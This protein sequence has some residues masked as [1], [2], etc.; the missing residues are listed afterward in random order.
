MTTLLSTSETDLKELLE[1]LRPADIEE[2]MDSATFYKGEQYYEWGL[3]AEAQYN[4][5]KTQLLARV[6]GSQDYTVQIALQQGSVQASCDCPVTGVCKHIAAVMLYAANESDAIEVGESREKG[7]L[8][9]QH[10]MAL[11]KEELVMRLLDYAP[12]EFLMEIHNRHAGEQE[13]QDAFTRAEGAIRKLFSNTELLYSPDD[14]ATHLH[15]H[16]R[17]LSGLEHQL[18]EELSPLIFYT[19]RK[20]E[21][22]FDNGYLYDDDYETTFELPDS[23]ITLVEQYIQALPYEAK[24]T[25]LKKLDDLLSETAYDVFESLAGLSQDSFNE[26]E[27]PA[28]KDMLLQEYQDLSIPLTEEYYVL[29]RSLLTDAEKEELLRYLREIDSSWVLELAY[30]YREED[31]VPEALEMLATGLQE[32]PEVYAD[33]Q[34]YALYLQLLDGQGMDPGPAAHQAL[35]AFASSSML[36]KIAVLEGIEELKPYEEQLEES[37]PQ[38]Y[39]EYLEKTGRLAEALQLLKNNDTIWSH[40]RHVFFKKH[41]EDFPQDAIH[42]LQQVIDSN[43]QYTG[44]P[45]YYKIIEALKLIRQVEPARAASIAADIRANYSNR[46]NLMRLLNDL[47][48]GSGA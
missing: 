21:E 13:A 47:E 42:H 41:I 15:R 9:H 45:H 39:L 32:N 36:L 4:F 25:F 14:F 5:D 31:R 3:V 48:G 23:F 6:E 28:V 7:S 24:T 18:E 16:I 20:I 29:V 1:S 43:L 2:E 37:N 44:N 10:L 12:D 8:V 34:V 19:I 30:L 26:D 11:P 40:Y 46:P 17:R 22:A 33:E 35:A 38:A 27:L